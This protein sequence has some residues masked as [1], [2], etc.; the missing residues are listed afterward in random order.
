MKNNGYKQIGAL[1]ADVLPPPHPHKSAVTTDKK[2]KKREIESESRSTR[3]IPM[4][5]VK[6]LLASMN[7]KDAV[8]LSVACKDWRA[9]AAEFDPTMWKTPWL[10]TTQFENPTC[11]LRSVV[12][13]EVTFKIELHGYPLKRTLF[14][15]CSRGWLVANPSTYS[16]PLLLNPFS[17]AWLQL[18]PCLIEPIF[19]LCMSAAPSNPDCVLLARDFIK[20]FYVWRPGDQSWTV[21]KGLVELFDTII[22]FEGQ[23]Y[24]WNDHSGCL[25][26]FRVLPLRLRKLMMPCPVDR[27]AYVKSSTSL[28]ECRGNILLVYVMEN[29]DESLVIFLFQLDLEKEM[30]INMESLGD[31]ALFMNIPSKRGV[32]VVASEA[33]C[34]ANCIYFLRPFPD[35]EFISYN[36]GSHSIERF[37]QLVNHGRQQYSYSQ[38]WI[39]PTLS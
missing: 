35:V 20:R 14:C 31:R 34:C 11:S 24:T 19:F 1:D 12:D 6:C 23:F 22:S 7:P 29:A 36:I 26:I 30:W 15:D 10:I 28:V 8:R 33:R 4:D 2:K 32:S 3:Y 38:F 21:E 37:P 17:R 16:G 5:I 25:T 27:S 9:A 13:K 39:T 18:P